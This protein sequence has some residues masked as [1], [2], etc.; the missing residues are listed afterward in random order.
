M[1]EIK[2]YQ[3]LIG[4]KW[5]D[6]ADG[7]TFVT[8]NPA[9][10]EPLARVP[11]AGDP[12][13]DAAVKAAKKALPAWR[14]LT[15]AQRNE[16][17]LKIAAAIREN[18]KELATCEALEH[19][20]PYQD[21][22]G[23]CMGAAGKFEYAA[24]IALAL[25][26][27]QIPM[28]AGQLSYFKRGPLG[29]AALVIPWNF[30]IIMLAVK[31]S[32]ALAVGNTCVIK[33]PSVNSMTDLVFARVIQSAGLPDGVVNVITGSGET[34]G[35]SLCSHP[36]VDV[37]GFTGSSETGQNVLRYAAATVKKCVMELGGNNPVLVYPDADLDKLVSVLGH[38]Q[39]NNCGQHC[40]GP[41][42]YYVHEK[43]YD[44]FLKKFA[45][46]ADSLKVGDP[47]EEGTF[48]GPVVS[49]AQ[50][51]KVEDFVASAVAEGAKVYYTRTK[52]PEQEKGSYVM[53]TIVSD[54]T[55]DM[56]IAREEV[57]GPVA[58]VIPW[59]DGDDLL[60][61]AND[62]PYGLCAH[63]WTADI[64]LALRLA[65]A[66]EVGNVFINCQTLTE[67]Q[68]WGTNVKASGLGREGGL[69]G[70][71]EF[72]DLKEITLEYK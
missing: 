10:G 56:K 52:T 21:A 15:Q 48:M 28:E 20:T 46:F 36:D 50:Q 23:V 31:A 33:P 14:A 9:T 44:E 25:M 43:V 32:A 29:V 57:F 67:E 45:A 12:D 63:V 69:E 51:K 11:R 24:S 18:A 16:Y 2:S 22:F 64:P 55:H 34:V 53:P 41:G 3:M 58:V 62:S 65:D 66:L 40:S 13:V 39:F 61:M 1:P 71:K 42:R 8:V 5:V 27:I 30:P 72:T 68:S 38:R 6:A 4:G 59:K 7:A 17:M 49:R 19:G 47:L 70:L 54:C 26:G 60:G 37:I 35:K